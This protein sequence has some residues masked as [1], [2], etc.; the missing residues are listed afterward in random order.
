[1]SGYTADALPLP[2]TP[3][4]DAELVTKPFTSAALVGAIERALASVR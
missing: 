2:H 1:M 3:E 4:P